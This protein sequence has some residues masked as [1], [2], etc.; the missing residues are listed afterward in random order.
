M[1]YSKSPSQSEEV[2]PAELYAIAFNCND[3]KFYGQTPGSI[4]S[5][6]YVTREKRKD[7]PNYGMKVRKKLSAQAMSV[8]TYLKLVS[9]GGVGGLVWQKN[10]YMAEMCSM[11]T[12]KFSECIQEL[13]HDMEQLGKPLITITQKKKFFTKANG[14][15]CA[16]R[17]NM[18]TP[19]HI[20]PENNGFMATIKYYTPPILGPI[21]DGTLSQCEDVYGTVSHC[22]SVPNDFSHEGNGTLSQCERGNNNHI[23]ITILEPFCKDNKNPPQAGPIC[24]SDEELSVMEQHENLVD[25]AIKSMKRFKCDDSFIRSMLHKYPPI[26]ILRAGKYVCKQMQLKDI[27]NKFG[28]LKTAIEMGLKWEE[29]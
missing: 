23:N 24:Y 15:R 3:P 17:Y 8:Y 20:W 27:K 16:T 7:S 21:E 11:S 10:S 22:E 28:Y 29:R 25:E 4:Y 2:S 12:G 5:C 6:T 9:G 18:I 13:S 1:S 26:R 19:V 14:K